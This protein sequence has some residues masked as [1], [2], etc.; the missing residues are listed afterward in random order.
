MG[1]ALNA[2]A[3]EYR[4][5]LEPHFNDERQLPT[6]L[7][8][9]ETTKQFASFRYELSVR[10]ERKGKELRYAI[11][12]LKTPQLSLPSSGPAAYIREYHD[13]KGKYDVT[14]ENL[15]GTVNTFAVH[16]TPRTIKLLKSPKDPFIE[17][18]VA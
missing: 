7:V 5:T 2:P 12:G 10:E 8:V 4:L 6:T 15:D 18:V 17:I 3:Y 13:L 14:V 16:I 9:L 11:L 1:K